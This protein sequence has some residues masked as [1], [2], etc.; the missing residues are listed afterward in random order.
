MIEINKIKTFLNELIIN[1]DIFLVD[2]YVKP[3]NRIFIELDSIQGITID[4]CVS[5]SRKVEEFLKD[6]PD[7]EIQVSSPGLGMPYKVKN[8]YFKNIGRKIE[9]LTNENIKIRGKLLKADNNSI[10]LEVERQKGK[11]KENIDIKT[12]FAYNEIKWAKTMVE[13]KKN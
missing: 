2:I 1:S 4:E 7:F 13:F 10:E 6:E 12:K 3:K 8:Q 11:P 9:I 5:I